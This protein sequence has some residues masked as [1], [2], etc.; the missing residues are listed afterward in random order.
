MNK[1]ICE[2]CKKPKCISNEDL[3]V[4]LSEISGWSYNANKNCIEKKY[5][6]DTFVE[7]IDFVGRVADI[8]EEYEHHPDI[9]ISYTNITL[10]L[11]THDLSCI[12]DID[13]ELAR[14]IDIVAE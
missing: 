7:G 2:T 10:S 14:K 6:F 9:V 11:S 5:S 8:A 13:F 3:E 4:N 12:S 1:E